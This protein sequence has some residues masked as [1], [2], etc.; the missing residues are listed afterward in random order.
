MHGSYNIKFQICCVLVRYPFSPQADILV[1]LSLVFGNCLQRRNSK[2]ILTDLYCVF[3]EVPNWHSGCDHGHEKYCV[4]V[5]TPLIGQQL[6]SGRSG[7][8]PN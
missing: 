4:R 8:V 6:R 3:T 7:T 1:F 5:E 2:R